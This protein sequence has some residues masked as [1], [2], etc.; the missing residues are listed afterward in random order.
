MLALALAALPAAKIAKLEFSNIDA[1]IDAAPLFVMF[2]APWCGHCKRLRPVWTELAETLANSG[3][4]LAGVDATESELLALRF[5]IGGYPTL[6]FFPN[7]TH[8][9]EYRGGRSKEALEAF[10]R[11]SHAATPVVPV[12]SRYGAIAYNLAAQAPIVY[13]QMSSEVR[14][15][16][17]KLDLTWD[18]LM[19]PAT[20]L[21]ALVLIVLIRKCC[22]GRPRPTMEEPTKKEE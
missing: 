15:V 18:A 10:A 8:M 19:H 6:L 22:C 11:G 13:K 21:L 17:S 7:A 16:F 9:H 3:V 2:Y 20:P 1:A 5:A 14:N 12:P 4:K